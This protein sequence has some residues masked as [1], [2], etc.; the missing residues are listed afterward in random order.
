MEK[1]I[2]AGNLPPMP[3]TVFTEKTELTD[4]RQLTNEMESFLLDLFR[5]EIDPDLSEKQNL[6]RLTG[7]AKK[8]LGILGEM[9]LGYGTDAKEIAL[10]A[11]GKGSD[12]IL[13]EMLNEEGFQERIQSLAW[14]EDELFPIRMRTD[15]MEDVPE[16]PLNWAEM[17]VADV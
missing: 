4:M 5:K 2:R 10:G 1:W 6:D 12:L 14:T 15:E 9:G 13:W 16:D 3:V 11:M 8:M 7:T 17:I